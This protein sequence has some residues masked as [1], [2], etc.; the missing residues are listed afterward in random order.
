MTRFVVDMS[1]PDAGP[2]RKP[3]LQ[4]V[5]SGHAATALRDDWRRQMRLCRQ[6]IG[7]P[8]VRFHGLLD[9]D[10]SVCLA[11]P[12]PADSAD[13]PATGVEHSFHNVDSVFDF[14]LDIGMKPFVELS[15]MPGALA[16]G[17]TT[18]FHYRANV[19]PPRDPDQWRDL[20]S[21]L[22]R[23]VV[24]R[25]GG[26][27][28]RQ[29]RFEV[30][31]EPNLDYFWTGSK[32]DYF[33]LYAAAARAVKDV[34]PAIPVG[35]P[36][37]ARN[38]WIPDMVRF[39]SSRGVALDFVSTHHYPT[40]AA[41][42]RD[43]ADTG[44][45]SFPR[46]VLADMA[47]AARSQAGAL[48]LHY[49]EWNSSPSSRDPLHDDP[50]AA[51]FLVKSALD[52]ADVVDTY[53][54]WAFSDIFEELGFPSEPFH[55]GFGLLSIHGVRKPSYRAFQLLA[56]LLPRRVVVHAEPAG[57]SLECT[58]TRDG[59][60]LALL[61][62]HHEPPGVAGA[63]ATALVE[64]RGFH[65][66][67]EAAVFRVDEDHA[68]PARTWRDLGCPAYPDH[69]TMDRLHDASR[70]GQQLITGSVDGATARFEVPV[71]VHSVALVVLGPAAGLNAGRLF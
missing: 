34:D 63:P 57:G 33:E 9:D 50:F 38:E 52:V 16:S 39:C 26:A 30:W 19:T 2:F 29:W 22:V 45:V 7:F 42:Q 23:H 47:R 27:E 60:G 69:K 1:A 70:P 67:A 11:A 41:V 37:T 15:F 58:A 54:W 53:A 4:C 3:F 18:A 71:P 51:A 13:P 25:Y 32:Q 14:L 61:L 6:E 20:V 44:S 10:M 8:F 36:A 59:D 17:T 21:A 35:G 43:A 49:T 46:G 48:P 66:K 24:D 62:S 5:G 31:N 28:V 55:G 56:R 64:V 12:D 68:N 65:G 40:D